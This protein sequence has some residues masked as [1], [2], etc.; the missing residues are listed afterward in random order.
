MRVI[1]FL[2]ITFILAGV[3]GGGYYIYQKYFLFGKSSALELVSPD[4]VFVFETYQPVMAWNQFTS[5]PFWERM[6]DMPSLQQAADQLNHLDS[7]FGQEGELEKVLRGNQFVLSMHPVGREEFDFLYT[8]AFSP[9]SEFGFLEKLEEN[10][11][12]LSQ[13]NTRSYSNV[14][15][16]EFQSLDLE[17]NL[18][19]TLIN[20]VLLISYTSFL[21]E[22]AIRYSQNS[23]TDNFKSKYKE[24][25]ASTV[26]PKGLGVLRISSQGIARFMEGITRDKDLTMIKSFARSNV[27]ANLELRFEDEKIKLDGLAFFA[28]GREM[29]WS[30]NSGI[31]K[32][33]F[34][35]FVSNRTAAYFNYNLQNP[36]QLKSIQD[37]GF[38]YKS[39]LKGD[40]DKNLIQKGFLED[41]TGEMG[42]MLFEMAGSEQQDRVLLVKTESA[43]QQVRLL[44][45]FN[46]GV[47]KADLSLIPVD[48]YLDQEIFIISAEEFPAHL[49]EGRFVGFP[50]TY[51]TSIGDYL[52]FANSSKAMKIYID[53]YFSDNIW[54]KSVAYKDLIENVALDAGFSLSVNIP[55]LYNT[56]VESSSPTWK[57]FFQKYAPQLKSLELMALQV[58]EREEGDQVSL[59]FGYNPQPIRVVS[60]VVLSENRSVQFE[61]QLVYGPKAIQNFVDRSTEF[62]VQDEQYRMHLISSEGEVVFSYPL[63]SKISTAIFQVDYYKNGK[64]QLLFAAGNQVYIIDR[65]GSLIPGFPVSP[66]GNEEIQHLNLV[67][68]NNDRDYRYFVATDAGK[69]FLLD[70]SGKG[71][72]GWN[73]KNVNSPLSS[74]PA[75]HRIAGVG[76][77]MLALSSAGELF[78]FNRRGEAELGSPIKLGNGIES[79]YILVERGSASDTRVVTVSSEGEIVHVNLRGE[80]AYRNQLER[81]D[82]ESKFR[83]IK[84]QKDDRYLFTVHEYNKVS[85]LDPESKQLFALDIFSE[86][87]T[88][89]FFSFGGDRNIFVVVDR[90]QE[91][92][93]LYNLKG[94]LLNSRPI[95]GT[96]TIDLRHS[97]SQNEYVIYVREG[98]KFKEY[99]LPV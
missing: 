76:D 27:S 24:L 81:P 36:R 39:T 28:D 13:I 5:Q 83:L 59:E 53:D 56:L 91:F 50:D 69:L 38:Q 25:F 61:S 95:G 90:D 71:L 12:P 19:Y 97:V 74:K 21:V 66:V 93:Y 42:Y 32:S 60:D 2:L 9:G 11:P 51:I 55:K 43:D 45:Q 79:D 49:F 54:G 92:V 89:Q 77:R 86:N 67:D 52:V 98:T 35:N 46:A 44:K 94:E 87:L 8:I 84:D 4:A 29:D 34:H 40:I 7:L 85:V 16:K 62:V 47:D 72:D 75:H 57:A 48:F 64:L 96:G 14:T 17:R 1:R 31:G 26:K 37:Q 22:E 15:I 10:I 58:K 30:H 80:L 20:N 99:K 73:P 70:R 23:G 3:I 63:E 33:D 65:L 41:L 88:F 18:N 78:F 6:S 82:R 68:Y